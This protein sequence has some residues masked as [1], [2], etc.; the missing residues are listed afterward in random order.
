VL[1]SESLWSSSSS[2][3]L[4]YGAQDPLGIN[5]GMVASEPSSES[6]IVRGS[7][8][9]IVESSESQCTFLTRPGMESSSLSVSSLSSCWK[10][11]MA[12]VVEDVDGGWL[13][14]F[15]DGLV[16]VRWLW[17]VWFNGG[18]WLSV[19]VV[20]WARFDKE[21]IF[22]SRRFRFGR[23]AGFSFCSRFGFFLGC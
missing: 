11:P 10:M 18:V 4:S 3:S 16:A 9:L 12:V 2:E 19:M 7:S 17:S 13:M 22:S 1:V 21:L 14:W 20:S 5:P 6:I 8:L 23:G 15:C